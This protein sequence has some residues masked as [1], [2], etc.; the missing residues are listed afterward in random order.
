VPTLPPPM[1]TP[2]TPMPTSMPAPPAPPAPQA[3]PVQVSEPLIN[4]LSQQSGLAPP[5]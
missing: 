2:P 5:L 1:P 3:P 4:L